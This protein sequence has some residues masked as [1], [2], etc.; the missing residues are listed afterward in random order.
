MTAALGTNTFEAVIAPLALLCFGVLFIVTA[1]KFPGRYRGVRGVLC[2]LLAV[3]IVTESLW[4]GIPSLAAL[5][6]LNVYVVLNF[7][8]P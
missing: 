1:P 4:L 7:S 6:I 2:V 5:A 8:D 3:A